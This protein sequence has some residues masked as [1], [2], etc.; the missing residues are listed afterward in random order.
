MSWIKKWTVIV[1]ICAF[2]VGVLLMFQ[3]KAQALANQGQPKEN[4]L[5]TVMQ[6][7]LENA[8]LKSDNKKI[9]EELNKY[10]EGVDA[11]LLADQQ[12][13]RAKQIA[14]LNP[15]KGPGV[16]ITLDDSNQKIADPQDTALYIIHEGYLRT[17][18][19]AL[20]NANA[21]AISINGQRITA[22]TEIFCNGNNILINRE[23]QTPPY[24]IDAI[25]D[26][27]SLKAVNF[28]NKF[29]FANVADTYGIR[30]EIEPAKELQLL[31]GKMHQ[32]TNA[33]PVKEGK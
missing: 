17:I 32:Y 7:D 24:T 30:L 4:I 21:E 6:Y 8:Q 23:I 5:Q 20:W 13:K 28:N 33:V 1:T 14:G 2:L 19:N 22:N 12:L 26:P 31:A 9:Q 10:K 29:D 18:V 15:V 11:A 25:G 27:Q 3:L 16:K